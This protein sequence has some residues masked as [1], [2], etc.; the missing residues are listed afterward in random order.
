MK[1]ILFF[2][3]LMMAAI[4]ITSCQTD[5]TYFDD[6]IR[7]ADTVTIHTVEINTSP[8]VETP[9]TIPTDEND[10]YYDDYI[11]NQDF[12]H[13]V[14]IVFDG[15]KATA[16][17][18]LSHCT[19]TCDGAHVVVNIVGKKVNLRLSGSTQNGSIKIYGDYKYGLELNGLILMNPHGAA[20]N[21]QNGKRMFLVLDD[22]TDNVL[23]D[24]TD[25]TEVEGESQ[26][27][28]IFSE[29]KI[30][31]SGKGRLNILALGK[32]GIVSDDYIRLRPGV[33]TYIKAS[34]KSGMKANDGLFIDGGI[35]N[36]TVEGDGARGLNCES[37]ITMKG[38]RTT[39][40]TSGNSLVEEGDTTS[41]T[42]VKCDSIL[43]VTGGS[44]LTK[45]TGEG[46]KGLNVDG[47]ITITGGSV[48]VVTTGTHVLTAPKG[49][50]SEVAI[51][52]TGGYL[53]SYSVNSQAYDA[54]KP[55][56]TIAPEQWLTARRYYIVQ[57]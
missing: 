10:P 48:T 9:E 40:L 30:L 6:I 50:K 44:L 3:F 42:A 46:G 37:V 5:D 22:D 1:K 39:I 55:T 33:Q 32:S 20:I 34:L 2:A 28:V 57:F 13:V 17:G 41:A 29:G 23:T 18:D 52:M 49:I 54:P 21:S 12:K 36:I 43:T 31:V 56:F 47:Q 15:E 8:V 51:N 7:N 35:H 11:E 27:G 16:T 14:D 19:A 38:G 45:S 4:V 25:Y 26:K 24:G 53:Y